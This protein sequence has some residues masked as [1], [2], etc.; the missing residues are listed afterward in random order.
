MLVRWHLFQLVQLF[1]PFHTMADPAARAAWVHEHVDADLQFIFQEAGMSEQVQYDIGQHYKTVR[2]FSALADTRA[3]LRTA[4]AADFTLRADNAAGRAEVAAVVAAWESSRQSYEEE[5]KLRQEAKGLGL[6]RP[7]PHTD[8]SAMLRAVEQSKGEDMAERE[9]PSSEYIALLLEEIEQDEV[10]AHTLDEITSKKDSQTL[11]LQSSL[12]QKKAIRKAHKEARPLHVTLKEAT[13]DTELKELHFT[14]PVTCAAMERPSKTPRPIRSRQFP[15]G[16]PWLTTS[17]RQKAEEGTAL[18]CKMWELFDIAREI[19]SHFLG[20]FPEDLGATSTGVPASIWQMDAFFSLLANPGQH[21]QLIGLDDSGKWKTGPAAHYPGELCL[22]IAKAIAKTFASWGR[23]LPQKTP[24][25]PSQSDGANF[26]LETFEAPLDGEDSTA[27]ETLDI[28]YKE[29]LSGCSGPPMTAR[30][31]GRAENFV[32][33]LGLCSPGR[34][35]P[36]FRAKSA[37]REQTDFAASLRDMVDKFCKDKIKDLAKQTFQLALGRFKE[38]PFSETDLDDLRRKWFSLLPDPRQAEVLV[39][40]QP[41]YLHALAQSLRQLGDPDVDIIDNS[42]GSSFVGGV[43]LG[44]LQPLGPTP[45]VYRRKVKQSKYDDSEWSQEMGNYFKGDECEAEK[46]LS[47]QFKEEELAGRMIFLSEAEVKRRYRD[48]SLRVAAQGILEK[49]DGGHR[50]IHDGTHGV[51]LNNQILIEDRLENPGPREMACIMETSMASGERCIFSLNADIAKA[52]RRVLVREEDWGV[53]AC[54]TSHFTGHLAKQGGDFRRGVSSFLVEQIDGFDWKT[55]NENLSFQSDYV[56]FWMDYSKFEIGLSERRTTWLVDF[57]KE[58]EHNDW[59]VNVK[60]FQEF[61]G[62]LGF[63]AQ[64]LP[65]LR[66]LLSPGYAWLAAVGKAATLRVPELLALSCIFIKEKFAK[67]LRK[68]PCGLKELELGELFRTDAKCEPGRVVLGGW[69]IGSRADPWE[70]S[71]FSLTLTPAEAPWLF[72]GPDQESSWASASAELLGSLVA[73]KVFDIGKSFQHLA[74]SHIVKCG[75][76]TDNKAASSVTSKRL[77]TKLPLLIILME[78]LGTCEEI[79]L[80]CHLDWRPRDTNTEADDLTNGRFEAFQDS[81]RIQVSW[82]GLDLPYIQSLMKH[83]ETFSKRRL[84]EPLQRLSE[85]KF[86]K[87][88]WG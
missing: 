61:H 40:G 35:H 48:Q 70:A 8:R 9:Q 4:L 7:L 30:Y 18:A 38:S 76:G 54:R 21:E 64:V 75:G 65:W 52:H 69:L 1:I 55:W 51:Q 86:Q 60:R 62:R 46:I 23:S 63:S 77:S 37:T 13:E 80:R 36:S 19:G 57:I 78:Y 3:D 43:H 44:H 59:L 83:S 82:S 74:A 85:G 24:S 25:H 17:N 45:Q 34:W 73:L 47:D 81:R 41:F 58:M 71:R 5:I 10:T 6:T 68:I 88:K 29:I 32:D 26:G 11:Q 84:S 53:Q 39:P 22:F 49:P 67:G 72:R 27:V 28:N 2:R 66:P 42:P 15:L 56:G 79:G 14:S 12:D 87:S 33:G 31:A 20:E 50:I 16:F